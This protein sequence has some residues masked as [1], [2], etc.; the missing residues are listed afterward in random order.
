MTSVKNIDALPVVPSVR[1]RDI[2]LLIAHLCSVDTRF[3]PWLL[4][5]LRPDL[6]DAPEG[7]PSTVKAIVNYTRPH[8]GGRAAGETDVLVMATYAVG[9]LLISIENKAWAAPQ[10][11][12]A[13]RHRA[14]VEGTDATWAYAIVLAPEGWLAGHRVETSGYHAALAL[15]EI[16]QWCATNDHPFH[17]E[18]FAT[19][20]TQPDFLPALDLFSWHD[21]LDAFLKAHFDLSLE[22]QR[23]V[24]TSNLGSSKPGRWP[25]FARHT[26]T[27]IR[28]LPHPWMMIRPSSVNHTTRVALDVAKA[29]DEFIHRIERSLEETEITHRVTRA[30]TAIIEIT[31]PD[32]R[33]WDTIADFA[34]QIPHIIAVGH[35]AMRFID[36]WEQFAAANPEIPTR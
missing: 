35:T 15:E 6:H 7:E 21:N 3:L 2:D 1:E 23:Y 27:P 13:Q 36:W 19:A 14:F 11:N 33:D 30:G 16:A 32:A 24:R 22:P 26:L 25:S 12:Q 34:L 17:S 8:A 29:P 31:V 9:D 28:G 20:C 10:R 18:V 4:R 5:S